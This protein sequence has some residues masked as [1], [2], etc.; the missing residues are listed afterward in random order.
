MAVLE[1][2]QRTLKR[3]H[4]LTS[5]DHYWFLCWPHTQVPS[6]PLDFT[7]WCYQKN[8][9]GD[10]FH[11]HFHEKSFSFSPPNPFTFNITSDHQEKWHINS[12]NTLWMLASKLNRHVLITPPLL[13]L[14]SF[15]SLWVHPLC[16]ICS[17][18][19]PVRSFSL[20]LPVFLL[21]SFSYSSLPL[22][23]LTGLCQSVGS[24]PGLLAS[25]PRQ[26]QTIRE[27]SGSSITIRRPACL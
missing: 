23:P 10:T 16:F 9:I 27:I 22:F 11:K 3:K 4:L 7:L 8:W 18:S 2:L 25:P 17:A 6:W 15:F 20:L 13:F 26:L 19:S 14:V 1:E 24:G 12:L 21:F 5:F